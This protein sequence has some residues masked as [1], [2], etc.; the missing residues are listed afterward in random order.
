MLLK[1]AEIF[2]P[3]GC[4][5]R[6]NV[7]IRNGKITSVSYTPADL[8]HETEV[9]D[10]NGKYLVPGYIDIH[11]HGCDGQDFCDNSPEKIEKLSR[12]LGS[13]GVTSYLGTTMSYDE[14]T[15]TDIL[16]GCVD[17]INKPGSGAVLRGINLEGPFFN[18]LKKGA[19]NEKYITAPDI[20]LFKRL[21]NACAG[22]IKI[23][24]IAPELKGSSEFIKEASQ[25]C[26][27][28]LAHTN[29][30]YEQ[31]SAAFASGATHVTHL[32]NAMPGFN[33]RDPSVVGAALDNASH[34]E[35][36]CDGI[37]IHPSVIRAVFKMFTA[38]R[39]CLISDSM[40]ACGLN[41][42][43]YTLGGQKVT[44]TG[45]KAVLDDN[46][47]AGSVTS[48][49][50]CVRNAVSFGIRPEDAIMAATLTP[51]RAADIDSVTGSIETGK[52]ADLQILDKNLMPEKVFVC[53]KPL[54]CQ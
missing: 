43:S 26:C 37:H 10:L 3:D 52:C 15:L 51:A 47:I 33:H 29:A 16:S 28:S 20:E 12:Y 5:R 49:A 41:D 18:K 31:A 22:N 9:I 42:G 44:V 11:T 45:A 24:D 23:V 38:N 36:I 17:Y 1:N 6:G 21:N 54:N 7:I 27:V 40:R 32:F 35:L 14:K 13:Q 39:I 8:N 30:D 53:G 50:K 19:Q 34:A 2:C 4:F 46:T 48:L 25:S